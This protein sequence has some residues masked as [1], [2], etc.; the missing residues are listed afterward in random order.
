[1]EFNK[2]IIIKEFFI[3]DFNLKLIRTYLWLYL[4]IKK[5]TT[6]INIKDNYIERTIF[7]KKN[8][9]AFLFME[10]LIL[11]IFIIPILIFQLSIGFTL[12][13]SRTIRLDLN[14]ENMVVKTRAR[15]YLY[16][17]LKMVSALLY[18]ALERYPRR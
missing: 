7:V 11:I 15:A 6:I 12:Q 2:F 17:S 1:M 10:N 3:N 16:W 5:T 9:I 18:D 8:E 13:I 14:W 4:Q